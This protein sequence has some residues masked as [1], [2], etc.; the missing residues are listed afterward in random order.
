MRPGLTL[1]PGLRYEL[2]THLRDFNNLGPRFGLTW[3]PFRAGRTSV[4]VSS[5]VFYD[6]LTMNTH[7]QTVRVDG[8]RQREVNIASPSYP[9]PRPA[10]GQRRC[11]P[12]GIS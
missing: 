7:E 4:R 6:W 5:G 11:R 3:S 2:Q 12:T 10:R 1:S 9:D 8:F